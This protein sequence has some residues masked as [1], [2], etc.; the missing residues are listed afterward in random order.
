VGTVA[1]PADSTTPIGIKTGV[2]AT[3]GSETVPATTSGYLPVAT[4]HVVGGVTSI[5]S[6]HITDLR[7]TIKPAQTNVTNEFGADQIFDGDVEIKGTLT[8][9]STGEIVNNAPL[10]QNGNVTI[11]ATVCDIAHLVLTGDCNAGSHKITSLAA[12]TASGDAANK[13]YVDGAIAAAVVTDSAS[14]GLDAYTG[15]SSPT[16][17]TNLTA[18]I[19]TDG[20]PVMVSIMPDGSS[21]ALFYGASS[22]AKGAYYIYRDGV[23]IGKWD[24]DIDLNRAPGFPLTVIDAPA[25]GTHTYELRASWTSGGNFVLSYA[26]LR[27]AQM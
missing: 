3:S 2:A 22:S 24:V 4:I 9:D 26:K 15:S 12:P 17:I 18:A 19:T 20:S 10:A 25:A 23:S 6:A 1:A 8:V 5:D 13:G 21:T 27:V 14:C 7:G 16:L 11:G